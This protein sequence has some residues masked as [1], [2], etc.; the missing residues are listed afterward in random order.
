M[1]KNN[2]RKVKILKVLSGD[3]VEVTPTEADDTLQGTKITVH[4]AGVTA[5]AKGE[6]GFEQSREYTERVL[7]G[8]MYRETTGLGYMTPDE[9]YEPI[10]PDGSVNGYFSGY[11]L[12]ALRDGYVLYTPEKVDKSSNFYWLAQ[13]AKESKIG[14]YKTCPNF[15]K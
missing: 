9:G 2:H 7:S 12:P 4:L 5:P 6:C 11:P 10:R 14:L 3:T 15:G 1:P 8:S 13:Q